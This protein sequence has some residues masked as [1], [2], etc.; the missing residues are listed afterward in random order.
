MSANAKLMV[1]AGGIR[2]TRDELATLH[3]PEPT[4]TWRPVPHAD[5]VAELIKGLEVQGITV[6]RDEYATTGR[7]DARLFGVM[8]L[9]IPD[10]GTPDFGMALGLRGANDRSMA[11]QVIAAAR[12]FVW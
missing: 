7:D 12:V 9:L 1:H 3:T 4:A 10:L 8:D 5:L 11:I 2:R 6:A